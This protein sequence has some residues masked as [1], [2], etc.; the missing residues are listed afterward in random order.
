MYRLLLLASLSLVCSAALAA[1]HKPNVLFIAVDDLKPLL[2]CYGDRTIKSPNF[3]RLAARG[4]VFNR[5]YCN[6]AVCAPSRNALMT[7]RR[8]TSLGIYDLG[9]NFRKAAPQTITLTQHFM[10]NGYRAEGIGKI[11]HIGH[12]NDDDPASWSVPLFRE[13]TVSYALPENRKTMTREEA[14]FANKA[15]TKEMAHGAPVEAADVPDDGYPDGRIATEA[16][17]RLH[18]AKPD[19]PFFMAVGFLKPHMPFCAPKKY[20]D[21]YDRAAF[22]LPERRTPPD[23]APAFAPTNW[24]EVRQYSDIPETGPLDDETARML[25]HGYHA[26]VSYV[27]AQL[28]RVLDALDATGLAEKTIIVLWGDHGWHLGD[29]GMW[30]K[31]TNYEEAARIPVIVAGPGIFKGKSAALIETVDIY[32]T[33][34]ELAGLPAPSAAVEGRSFVPALHDLTQGAKDYILHTF[35]RGERI[36][37]ALRTTQYRLVEWKVPGAPADRAEIELYDYEND[38]GETKNA[39]ASQPDVVARL[40]GILSNQFPE[41]KPQINSAGAKTDRAALFAKRD[42]NQDGQL[43][44][45]EFLIG[46]PDP[47]EAPKRFEKFDADKNGTLSRDE[48]IYSGAI[49]AR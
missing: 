8:P 1:D 2:G 49:P 20:W 46:Q 21:L 10:A 34:A 19:E 5:A 44:R 25:I 32:P 47:A 13:K 24:S 23:G 14:L 3:D 6:Q 12:G 26:A 42:K 9:T 29:H 38:P 4:V 36:G 48:F 33:L 18:A 15:V 27:D 40:R 45:E 43:T 22:S 7:G 11:F 17:R 28:G 35:P 31:H 37:R 30:S 41:A 39:A 16:V